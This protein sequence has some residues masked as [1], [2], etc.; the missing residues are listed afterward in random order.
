MASLTPLICIIDTGVHLA[1]LP[2]D[3]NIAGIDLTDP[4]GPD[5]WREEKQT[6]AT[7]TCLSILKTYPKCRIFVVKIVAA[8]GLTSNVGIVIEAFDWICRNAESLK[9]SVVCVPLADMSH[10]E[11]DEVY[12]FTPAQKYVSHLRDVGIATVAAAGNW[13]RNYPNQGMAWPAILREVVSVG[14]AF[15]HENAIKILPS[16]QRLAPSADTPCRTSIFAVCDE[17]SGTSGASA[18]ISA[19][20]ALLRTQAPEASVAELVSKL[21]EDST[22]IL[23]DQGWTWTVSR[24]NLR[25]ST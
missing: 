24:S 9:I 5:G 20:L 18:V 13:G 10:N 12:R 3:A 19:R 14:A 7:L 25:N 17:T 2:A 11:N 4:D 23:D 22:S 6:H 16:S 15:D 8:A 21:V 1:S